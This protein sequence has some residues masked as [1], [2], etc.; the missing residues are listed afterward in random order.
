MSYN[1]IGDNPDTGWTSPQQ[2]GDSSRIQIEFSAE[3]NAP[4]AY[5]LPDLNN[6]IDDTDVHG[7]DETAFRRAAGLKDPSDLT[8]VV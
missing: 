3:E 7:V 4:T 6:Y 8:S 5:T 2:L 1:I